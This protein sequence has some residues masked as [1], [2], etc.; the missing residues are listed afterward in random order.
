MRALACCCWTVIKDGTFCRNGKFLPEV[1]KPNEGYARQI[2]DRRLISLLAYVRSVACV[3]HS[4]AYQSSPAGCVGKM[5]DFIGIFKRR[6]EEFI[7]Q[8]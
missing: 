7:E 6:D 4:I 2:V 5:L 3:L 8:G 1:I